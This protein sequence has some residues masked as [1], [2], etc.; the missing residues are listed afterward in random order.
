MKSRPCRG[1]FAW[2][3]F[4][5][6]WSLG[7][8]VGA[9]NHPSAFE[10][11]SDDLLV[12]F[13]KL[14]GSFTVVIGVFL[15]GAWFFRKSRLF[16]LYQS[17]TAHLKILETRSLGYRNSLFVVGYENR[18]FL[19]AASSTGINLVSPL[20]DSMAEDAD[21]RSGETFAERLDAAKEQKP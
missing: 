6:V 4:P 1:L 20:P 7:A 10:S 21:V 18:R 15:A 5:V 2:S 14:L 19:L 8:E 12:V 3:V 13:L 9:T 11:P 16:S 17:K